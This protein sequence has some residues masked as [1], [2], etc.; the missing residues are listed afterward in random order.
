MQTGSNHNAALNKGTHFSTQAAPLP[1]YLLEVAL[2]G[3]VPLMH[4]PSKSSRPKEAG[5]R[6]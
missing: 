3:S 4:L 5:Y 2:Q 6:S 1:Y